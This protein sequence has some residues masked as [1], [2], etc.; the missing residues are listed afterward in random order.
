MKELEVR[1]AAE[2]AA[3][4]SKPE[5]GNS[6][7]GNSTATP[8]ANL[9]GPQLWAVVGGMM[10]GVY[11][12]GLDLTMLST[13][14]PTLTDYFGTIN[15]VAWYET[16]YVLAVCVLIPL[17]GKI[18][19]IF[20][21]KYTYFVFMAVFQVGS[22][23]CA[24][25]KSSHVFIIGRAVNGIGS[26]GL[27]S[28]ALLIIFAACSPNIRPV[29]TSFA[30]SLISVGAIT[31]PLIAGALTDH[32][33]WRW[34]F[35]MFLPFGGAVVAATLPITIPE[36]T[37][38]P[39]FHE[40]IAALQKLD[41]IGFVIFA[42]LTTML[43][44]A[45]TWGGGLYEWSSPTI[46]GLLCG[47]VGL[48]VVFGAWIRHAGDDALIP[49]SSLRRRSV[50]VGS[51]VMFLQGGATQMIPYFLPFW[52]QAIRGDSPAAS[53]VHMLPSLISN[54]IALIA[55]GAL[56]R[57]FHYIPPW[58]IFGSL[59]AS[60]GAGLLTTLSPTSTTGQWIGYQI[61]TTFGRGMAFQVPVVSVQE[62]VPSN[63]TATAL[64]VINLFMNLGCAIAVAASQTIFHN[65]LPVLLAQHAPGVDPM[66]VMDA[67]ATNIRELVSPD[68]LRGL[69]EA[70][71]TALTQIFA[72]KYLPAA[73]SGLSCLVSVGM[74]WGSIGV[75]DGKNKANTDEEAPAAKSSTMASPN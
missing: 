22:I 29:V 4:N 25:A 41:G 65:Y 24:V 2:A 15:D 34:C 71:N 68:E 13:I 19:T 5:L 10:L 49:P 63:E 39:P 66:S 20:N 67:G 44:F 64:A 18:Y 69:L 70:Y 45:T 8:G 50:A 46:I 3:E 7:G 53:A 51:V 21:N 23:I 27:L 35:W 54:I 42:G 30:M 61:I 11:L 28:G 43:L 33:T 31:G 17:V 38:K 9:H 1:D 6:V 58:S 47:A 74:G 12:V 59:L 32:V 36:Q 60:V 75:D 48:T 37:P 52:F 26:A 16:A 55:F 72:L 57:K 40:A 56:V 62:R 73:C 14:V